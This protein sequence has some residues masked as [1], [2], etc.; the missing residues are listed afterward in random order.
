QPSPPI[1]PFSRTPPNGSSRHFSSPC[2]NDGTGN[3]TRVRNGRPPRGD[4]FRFQ[5][6]STYTAAPAT[7]TTRKI[8][9]IGHQRFTAP[10]LR[11]C[12]RHFNA[13]SENQRELK[14][15]SQGSC[16]V[17]SL[18]PFRQRPDKPGQGS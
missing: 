1:V 13:R 5:V 4:S 6:Q 2:W 7:T 12:S 9:T 3:S 15:T 16:S 8:T 10:N 18:F 14:M 11:A 17:A